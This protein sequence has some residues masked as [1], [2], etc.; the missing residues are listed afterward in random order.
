MIDGTLAANGNSGNSGG[1]ASG[2]G[3]S[4]WLTCGTIGGAGTISAAGG[5]DP[6]GVFRTLPGVSIRQ[7][8]AAGAR[9]QRPPT[10]QFYGDRMAVLTDPY[11]HSWSIA[12][13]I[14]DVSEEEM[15]RRAKEKQGG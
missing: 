8:E 13:H 11:E 6:G 3:G 7:A 4:L 10:D 14:E 5:P 15:A 1:G 12:T 2:S 9:V